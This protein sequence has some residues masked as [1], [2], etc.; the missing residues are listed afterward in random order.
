MRKTVIHFL[1]IM[2]SILILTG[3]Q[4]TSATP[5]AGQEGATASNTPSV[6]SAPPSAEKTELKLVKYTPADI[7]DGELNPLYGIKF[8]ENVTLDSV[9]IHTPGWDMTGDAM[10]YHMSLL[11]PEDNETIVALAGMLGVT[12]KDVIDGY[13][14]TFQKEGRIMIDGA[15]TQSGTDCIC[16]IKT[17]PKDNGWLIQLVSSIEEKNEEKYAKFIED[18]YNMNVFDTVLKSLSLMPVP[19]HFKINVCYVDV[20]DMMKTEF[21]VV[22]TVDNRPVIMD[23]LLTGGGYDW[24]DSANKKI[25]IDYGDMHGDVWFTSNRNQINVYQSCKGIPATPLRDYVFKPVMTLDTYGFSFDTQ[26]GISLYEDRGEQYSKLGFHSPAWGEMDDKW[27]FEFL[28]TF[29]EGMVVVWYRPEENK[30][31]IHIEKGSDAAAYAF[32]I[33]KNVYEDMYPDKETVD[34]YLNDLYADSNIDDLYARVFEILEQYSL[35]ISGKE[36]AQLA[37]LPAL[38]KAGASRKTLSTLGFQFKEY[39]SW[40]CYDE[41]NQVSIDIYKDT[42]SGQTDEWNRNVIWYYQVVNGHMLAITYYPDKLRCEAQIYEKEEPVEGG[43]EA[44][45]VYDSQNKAVL[46]SSAMGTEMTPEEFFSVMLGIPQTGTLFTD[47]M[48]IFDTYTMDQFS[49]T[50]E[51]LY[52]LDTE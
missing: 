7:L 40:G 3:C 10:Q 33:E 17:S 38:P 2:L 22:Y 1:I 19:D 20:D 8:P 5:A 24:Y 28:Y 31:N 9:F 26:K 42:W 48:G 27:G 34:K 44:Y 25:G 29:K 18:N 35:D 15:E 11:A 23:S 49:M 45:F 41:K 13:L 30:Y 39:G 14:E 32:N 47:V 50:P 6:T 52:R 16:E 51:E 12:S 4:N 37:A 21:E 46:D 36:F 43:A